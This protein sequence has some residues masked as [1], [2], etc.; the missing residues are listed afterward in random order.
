MRGKA[1]LWYFN[2]FAL[3]ITP[4]HAGKSGNITTGQRNNRD[5]PRACGEK[6]IVKEIIL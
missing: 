5:H 6:E 1:V 2:F 3:R 4:A